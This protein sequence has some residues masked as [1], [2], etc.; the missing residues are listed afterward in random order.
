MTITGGRLNTVL[1]RHWHNQNNCRPSYWSH[2]T[3]VLTVCLLAIA[4]GLGV[5]NL[6]RHRPRP[7]N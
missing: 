7:L 6:Y 4:M 2:V 1:D 5:V 3:T